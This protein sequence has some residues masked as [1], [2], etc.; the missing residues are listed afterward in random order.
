MYNFS[1]FSTF[2]PSCCQIW[3]SYSSIGRKYN[4]VILQHFNIK[5]I[6]SSFLPLQ[7]SLSS[8]LQILL[9]EYPRRLDRILPFQSLLHG[10]ITFKNIVYLWIISEYVLLNV[11]IW[12]DIF[13]WHQCCTNIYVRSVH[14]A[15]TVFDSY[16]I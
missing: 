13:A 2:T 4:I 3:K 15:E 10:I 5:I 8:L 7:S 14:A 12:F 9:M 1:L 6:H 11:L 16:F